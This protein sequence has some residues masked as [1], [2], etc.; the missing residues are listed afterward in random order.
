[1]F[2]PCLSILLIFEALSIYIVKFVNRQ[3]RQSMSSFFFF[4]RT[5][6]TNFKRFKF[7]SLSSPN[8][9]YLHYFGQ[10]NDF[11]VNVSPSLF[12]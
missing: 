3:V 1:M 6:F 2:S 9:L 5:E 10:I 8:V 4:I 11:L 7:L 12:S